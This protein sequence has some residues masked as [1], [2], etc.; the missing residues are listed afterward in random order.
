M[1]TAAIFGPCWRGGLSFTRRSASRQASALTGRL[2]RAFDLQQPVNQPLA[3]D[4]RFAPFIDPAG[5]VEHRQRHHQSMMLSRAVA[6][7]LEAAVRLIE[8]LD[9]FPGCVLVAETELT[10]KELRVD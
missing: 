1:V 9:A 3:K 6:G 2:R 4:L 10:G 5:A 7:A 8:Q